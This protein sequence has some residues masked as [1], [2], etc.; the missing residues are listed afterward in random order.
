MTPAEMPQVFPWTS[1]G[2]GTLVDRWAFEVPEKLGT[3]MVHDRVAEH[4]QAFLRYVLPGSWRYS[5][6]RPQGQAEVPAE[7][8]V[9]RLL[10]TGES[11]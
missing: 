10:W 4:L 6:N 3:R 9:M 7:L 1:G 8:L 11:R 2:I 5:V